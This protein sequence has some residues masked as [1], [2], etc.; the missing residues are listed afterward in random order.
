MQ[1]P[2]FV[3]LCVLGDLC[4]YLRSVLRENGLN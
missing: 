3:P 4:G 2:L 1:P